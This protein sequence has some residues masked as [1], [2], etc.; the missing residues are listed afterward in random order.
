MERVVLKYLL[1]TAPW[2]NG[3]T[4]PHV[5]PRRI[6]NL[7]GSPETK[8]LCSI[9]LLETAILHRLG[10]FRF[11]GTIAEFFSAAMATDLEILD[12]TPAIAAKTNEV[13]DAFPGDPFDRTIIATAATL[14][15]T[16]ITADAAIRDARMCDVEYYPFKPSR[17]PRA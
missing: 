16:L 1:D 15:L 14:G 17:V 11:S 10:R 6:Q 3:L 5:L 8:H 2:V 12:L 9:R 4:M 13:P 7:L